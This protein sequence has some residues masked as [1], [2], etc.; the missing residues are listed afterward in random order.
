TPL[1]T[2]RGNTHLLRRG[3][4]D[5]PEAR[6]EALRAIEAETTRMSR[7]VADLLLLARADAG[8]HLEMKPV[9]LD[10]LLLEVYRQAQLLADGVELHL[11]NEDQ[12][13]V[14]GDPDRLKQA[15]LNLV[16]NGLKYTPAGGQ[17]WVSLYHD[18]EWVRLEVR[19]TGMGIP[20]EDLPHIFERF[21]RADRARGSGGGTGLG[22]SI[23]EWIVRAHGGQITV[24]S[25]VGQGSTF[26]IWLPTRPPDNLAVQGASHAPS[27]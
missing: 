6:E 18:Q 3:A 17:V 24:E 1:T 22:L 15:L 27:A 12:A 9:E 10:T 5:D 11:G 20:P 26:T 21:Y 8:T 7:L 23:A 4:A 25:R 13:A 16:D 14:V 2:I 19:D